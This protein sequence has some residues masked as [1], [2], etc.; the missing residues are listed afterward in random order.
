MIKTDKLD[1]DKKS[2]KINMIILDFYFKCMLLYFGNGPLAQ[3]VR[4]IGS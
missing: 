3:L 1:Y 4:A 2:N